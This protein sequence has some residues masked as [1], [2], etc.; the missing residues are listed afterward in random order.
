MAV[1]LRFR[2]L[3]KFP[4]PLLRPDQR[5]GRPFRAE[6]HATRNDLLRELGNLRATEAEIS[7]AVLP[8][9]I[10]RDGTMPLASANPMHPGVVLWCHTREHGELSWAC[11]TCGR[12]TDNLRAIVLTLERLRLADLYDVMKGAQYRG[13]AALPASTGPF[14]NQVEAI[15]YLAGIAGMSVEQ[16]TVDTTRAVRKALLASHPDQGG[17]PVEFEKVLAARERLG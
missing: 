13:F 5:K 17:D 15:Q 2:T 3:E 11:D 6:F 9:E 10:R 7:V 8:H 1:E 12:W 16:A 4:K 14:R